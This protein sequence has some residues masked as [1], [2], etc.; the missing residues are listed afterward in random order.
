MTIKSFGQ[1]RILLHMVYLKYSL[2]YQPEHTAPVNSFNVA[3]H[4]P[5]ITSLLLMIKKYSIT[6]T[7]LNKDMP[8]M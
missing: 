2:Q 8:L 3:V 6:F 1:G 7:F 5:Q 4:Q